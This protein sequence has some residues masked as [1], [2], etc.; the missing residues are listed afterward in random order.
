MIIAN[1]MVLKWGIAGAIL[2]TCIVIC[3][4]RSFK[5]E[6]KAQAHEQQET[7]EKAE[8]QGV[9]LHMPSPH[10]KVEQVASISP[11]P[12][13]QPDSLLDRQLDPAGVPPH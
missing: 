2:A 7:L 1:S 4:C 10:E 12:T 8:A 3:A 13:P 11:T 6:Q 9:K 5:D